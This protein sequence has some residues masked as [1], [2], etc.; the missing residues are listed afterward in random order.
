MSWHPRSPIPTDPAAHHDWWLRFSRY[1]V[2]ACIYHYR[3]A[4]R[5]WDFATIE[6][7]RRALE[8]SLRLYWEMKR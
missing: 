7:R 2:R 5:G 4:V 8:Q 1:G 6:M 3:Q